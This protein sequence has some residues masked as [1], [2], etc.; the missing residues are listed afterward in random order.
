MTDDF[1]SMEDFFADDN[2]KPFDPEDE[3]VGMPEF[4]QEK[5]PEQMIKV[6]F[7]NDEDL[8]DFARLI[9]QKL[10]DRTKSIWHPFKAHQRETMMEYF[11][12]ES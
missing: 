12:D 4:I 11:F 8:Q 1:T 5:K 10:T 7:E 3:W 6:R 2:E 9:G